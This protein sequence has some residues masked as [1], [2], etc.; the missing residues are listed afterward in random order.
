MDNEKNVGNNEQQQQPEQPD[1]K[2][3]P[4]KQSAVN[5]EEKNESDISAE[6]LAAE[7][8]RKEAMTERD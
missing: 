5:S 6:D 8:Q 3:N 4:N 7:Q 1:E 2:I